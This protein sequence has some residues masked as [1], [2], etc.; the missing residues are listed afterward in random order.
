MSMLA[1]NTKILRVDHQK[2]QDRYGD[3]K[4]APVFIDIEGW[5]VRK[6]TMV[7]DV[8][9]DFRKIDAV[10]T[11]SAELELKIGNL[12]TIDNH[13]ADQYVVFS[14]AE[15]WDVVGNLDSRSYQLVKQE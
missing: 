3:P 6:H 5:M 14:M 10:L 2:S 8:T 15:N 13:D 7:R 1:T 4:R 12:L 11:L 9:G